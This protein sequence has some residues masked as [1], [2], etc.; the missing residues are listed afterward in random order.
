M[1]VKQLDK[2]YEQR[3]QDISN[4]YAD[5]LELSERCIS[6]NFNYHQELESCHV[7][8]VRRTGKPL[9]GSDALKP[10]LF[11]K[12]NIYLYS[13]LHLIRFGHINASYSCL[14]TVKEHILKLYFLCVAD[15]KE[16]L[17]L[18][19]E[20]LKEKSPLSK[21]DKEK[22]REYK[23][24][25]QSFLRDYLYSQTKRDR[26]KKIYGELSSAAHPSIT[27]AFTDLDGNT[28]N[29]EDLL[30]ILPALSHSLLVCGMEIYPDDLPVESYE[31]LNRNLRDFVRRFG[32][33]ADLSPDK[34]ELEKKLKIGIRKSTA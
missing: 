13:T 26:L 21:E 10:I 7:E 29:V 28:E 17:L 1:D 3:K 11:T 19:K 9:D 34:P 25:N 2:L 30:Q 8:K 32:I 20:E 22:I 23:F 12:A 24:F 4:R 5:L 33:Y 31:R 16:K 6:D 18:L 14:R 27:G 15:D